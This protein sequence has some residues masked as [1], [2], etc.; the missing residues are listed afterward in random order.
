MQQ[1]SQVS[2]LL[3]LLAIGHPA[4]AISDED[5][6]QVTCP[7]ALCAN[8]VTIVG[9]CCPS[10][11][12][13]GCMFKGCVT[14]SSYGRPHWQPT[15]CETCSCYNNEPGCRSRQCQEL[16]ETD[17]YGHPVVTKPNECCQS[18]DFGTPATGCHVVRQ[19]KAWG[20]KG[21]N[22]KSGYRSCA[23]EIFY[24]ECDKRGFRADGKKYRCVPQYGKRMVTFG[25]WCPMSEGFYQDVVQC[26]AV[27]DAHIIV[28]CDLFVDGSTN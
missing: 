28:G 14:F 2:T 4:V 5:C 12:G 11:V 10:C 17:C 3:L 25:A 23:E 16:T 7:P 27:E 8:P 21:I 13:S 19:P 9:E 20:Q 22:I 18:C 24:H 6:S 15:P 1:Y 26:N